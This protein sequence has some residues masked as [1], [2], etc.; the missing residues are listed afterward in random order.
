ME[1]VI[2]GIFA[3]VALVSSLVVVTHKSP[4][5][6][7]LALVLT[8]FSVAVLFVLLGAPFVVPLVFGKAYASSA[9][10]FSV[11]SLAV[12]FRRHVAEPADSHSMG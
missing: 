9:A 8:L 5:Y 2:F 12:P 7:T 10:V 4:I 3:T 6:A 11:M 1:T